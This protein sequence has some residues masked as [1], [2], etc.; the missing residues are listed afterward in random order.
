M[1]KDELPKIVTDAVPGPKAAAVLARRA[2]AIPSAIRTIYPVVMDKAQ[3]AIIQDVD[4][5]KFLDFIGGV[6]VLNI[7]HCHPEVVEAVK[8]QADK[9]FHGMFNVVTHEGYVALA[10]KLN[11]IVPVKGDVKRTYFANSGAEANENAIKLAKAYTKRPNVIVF[12]GA[13]HGRTLLTMSMTAKKAY[14]LGQGPFP[15]GIYRAEFPYLYRKPEGMPEDKA[16]EFYVSKLEEVFRDAAPADSVAAIVVEPLQGEGGFIPVPIEWIKEIRKI[17]DKYGILL[18]ADEVQTGFCRTGRFFATE[19]WKDAGVQPDIISMAKSIAAGVPLA[20]I[21]AREELAESVPGGVIGGTFG[22]NALACAAALKTIEIMERDNLA[23]RSADIGAKVVARYKS[24]A[25]KFDVVGDIRGLGGMVGIEF[26]KDQASKAPAT[27]LVNTLIK[28][29]AAHGLLVENAGTYG[30]VIR[31]LAPL[32][33]TDEQLEAGLDIFEA[34]LTRAV[35][36]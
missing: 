34:A 32:V 31:F 12:S 6:G 13:F 11:T 5:N 21:T 25:D 9:Y 26:I 36:K 15:D 29:M 7:G 18:I 16:I 1:L 3:G 23:K 27:D 17:C 35:A 14:A 33:I 28:D 10:E 24:W 8:A 4:G 30:N 2:K 19:Y 22:G 20:A